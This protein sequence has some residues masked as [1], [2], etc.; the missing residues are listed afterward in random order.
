MKAVIE[1]APG[2]SQQRVR[3]S[4]IVVLLVVQEPVP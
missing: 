4:C 1:K 2:R 3:A